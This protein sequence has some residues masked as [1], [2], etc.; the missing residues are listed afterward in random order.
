VGGGVQR[1]GEMVVG[2][3]LEPAGPEPPRVEN[4]GSH[5]RVTSP[6]L[7][8]APAWPRKVTR[9]GKS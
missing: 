4:H 7:I 2:G 6:A 5:A 9:I 3:L 1:T 8:S